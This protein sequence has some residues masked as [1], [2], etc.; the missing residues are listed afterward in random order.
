MPIFWVYISVRPPSILEADMKENTYYTVGEICDLMGVTR[1]TLFY[2]DRINLLKPSRR[3]GSQRHKLYDQNS[4]E[5][6][7]RILK[8]RQ[9]GLNV[10]EIRTILYD[11]NSREEDAL[12]EAL[13]RLETEAVS[14]KTQITLLK[15]M[16][17]KLQS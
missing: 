13:K 1:K 11:K 9:A 5:Q 10:S 15:Q 12:N 7:K 2:Y 4:F 6:L 8:Y 3:E 16:I 17:R 14:M